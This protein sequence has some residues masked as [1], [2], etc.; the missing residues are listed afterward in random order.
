[1]AAA[2]KKQRVAALLDAYGQTFSQ[3]LGIGL[4][5]GNSSALF[6]WLCAALLM[7]ARIGNP[8]AMAAART[9]YK[10]GWTSAQKLARST[11]KQRVAAL[12]SAGYVRYDER[13]ATMLGDTAQLALEEY[14]GDLRKLREAA[15]FDPAAERRLLKRFK[16]IGDVGADIFFREVQVAWKEL[17]PFADR[18]AL[19]AARRLGLPG[20]ARSLARLVSQKDFPRLVATLVRVDLANASDRFVQPRGVSSRRDRTRKAA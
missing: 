18:R 6:R 14:A 19:A 4:E 17:A 1:M 20:D 16:G 9:L 12:D 11:W 15:R 13:T 10:R 8:I 2:S 3:E 7:S 5:K